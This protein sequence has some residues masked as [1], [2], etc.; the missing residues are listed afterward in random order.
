MK[1]SL[2]AIDLDLAPL[3][4]FF[5]LRF[6]ELDRFNGFG[7]LCGQQVCCL[8][9]MIGYS[10]KPAFKKY[11]DGVDDKAVGERDRNDFDEVVFHV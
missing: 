1:P 5:M 6:R 2:Q 4:Q 10:N 3:S 8:A 7:K 11:M 9:F